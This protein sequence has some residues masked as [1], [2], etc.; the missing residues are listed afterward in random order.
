[1]TIKY[2]ITTFL[3]FILIA[4]CKK[5]EEDT[6][7]IKIEG[8]WLLIKADG[9]MIEQEPRI[10]NK[11]ELIIQHGEYRLLVDDLQLVATTYNVV[12]TNI[13]TDPRWQLELGNQSSYHIEIKKNLLYVWDKNPE[14]MRLIYQ[15][16]L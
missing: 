6:S 14:G 1:M 11:Q 12:Q 7:T 8:K 10:T 2:W 13:D 3:L 15:R 4:S 5:K 9:D 16:I